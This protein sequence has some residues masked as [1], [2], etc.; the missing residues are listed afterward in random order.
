MRCH[1]K[2]IKKKSSRNPNDQ[3]KVRMPHHDNKGRANQRN[4]MKE[5]KNEIN[6]ESN[7]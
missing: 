1:E 2:S 5:N 4:M 6:K 7:K 3:V